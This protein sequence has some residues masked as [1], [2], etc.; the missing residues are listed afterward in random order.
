MLVQVTVA[1]AGFIQNG[2]AI[3]NEL[4]T[5][6]LTGKKAMTFKAHLII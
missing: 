3:I 6:G 2:N 1:D 5:H 4:A